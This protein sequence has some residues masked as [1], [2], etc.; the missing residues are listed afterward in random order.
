VI[1]VHTNCEVVTADQL[2]PEVTVFHSLPGMRC[3]DNCEPRLFEVEKITIEKTSMLK[4]GKKRKLSPGFDDAIRKDL[5]QWRDNE[6]L[7][8]FYGGT[9]ILAGSTLLGDDVIEKLATCGERIETVEDFAQHARWPIGFNVGMGASTEY[10][11]MLLQRLKTIYSKFD[12]DAAADEA[13]LLE[14]HSLPIQ[15]DTASFYGS[16][17]SNHGQNW[18]NLTAD[19]YVHNDMGSSNGDQIGRGTRSR[20]RPRGGNRGRATHRARI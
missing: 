19:M 8:K 20:G 1:Y 15:V 13:R 11:N 14:L 10:G 2:T 9:T 7:D 4:R 6:L 3:C 5:S 17:S 16:G 12:E 18:V